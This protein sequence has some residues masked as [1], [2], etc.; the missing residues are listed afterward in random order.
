MFRFGNKIYIVWPGT[1]S[2][3]LF[4]QLQKRGIDLLAFFVGR[5]LQTVKL[6]N[7]VNWITISWCVTERQSKSPTVTCP[8]CYDTGLN[9]SPLASNIKL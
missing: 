9:R 2:S 7:K 8:D 1:K 3:V 4:P 6:V 5:Q